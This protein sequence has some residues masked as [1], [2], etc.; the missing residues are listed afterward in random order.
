MDMNSHGG[1]V[2]LFASFEM[3]H[4]GL[5]STLDIESGAQ[6]SDSLRDRVEA[7]KMTCR[8]IGHDALIPDS[9]L[10]GWK[11]FATWDHMLRD[12]QTNRS[13]LQVTMGMNIRRFK[14]TYRA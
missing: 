11:P 10:L 6:S 4:P 8:Q 13:V 12:S 1:L 14:T 5:C 3:T 7:Q 9:L 2:I